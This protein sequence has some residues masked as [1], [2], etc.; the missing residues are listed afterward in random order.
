MLVGV[1][2]KPTALWA[3]GVTPAFE[4][5]KAARRRRRPLGGWTPTGTWRDAAGRSRSFWEQC[6]Q[7]LGRL[8]APFAEQFVEELVAPRSR[9]L[10]RATGTES[11][12]AAPGT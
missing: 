9:V 6:A 7:Q 12:A 3:G 8:L 5:L 2:V 10:A 11:C 4:H 1:A